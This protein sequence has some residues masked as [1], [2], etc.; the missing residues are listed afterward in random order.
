[1]RFRSKFVAE[2][3]RTL[4]ALGLR[5]CPVCGSER[6]AFSEWPV[7]LPVKGAPWPSRPRDKDAGVMYAVAVR[8]DVCGHVLLFD[9]EC[10]R[11]GGP[12]I[13]TSLSEAEGDELDEAGPAGTRA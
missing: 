1:M 5:A 4:T 3:R 2:V 13:V 9:S 12:P 11:A 7:L 10:H 8:C 6:L